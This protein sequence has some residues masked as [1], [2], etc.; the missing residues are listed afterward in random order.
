M[1]PNFHVGPRLTRGQSA[2]L[3]WRLRAT[4]ERVFQRRFGAATTRFPRPTFCYASPAAIAPWPGRHRCFDARQRSFSGGIL[5]SRRPRIC[6]SAARRQSVDD[7]AGTAGSDAGLTPPDEALVGRAPM[8][9][10]T[11]NERCQGE[12]FFALGRRC[13]PTCRRAPYLYVK[14]A[15]AWR[16]SHL[17]LQISGR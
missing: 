15:R 7:S 1:S 6:A 8:G 16:P 14:M 13:V 5:G 9:R 3:R 12:G 4:S 17:W 2:C 10:G 11:P